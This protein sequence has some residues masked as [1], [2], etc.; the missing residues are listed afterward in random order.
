MRETQAVVSFLRTAIDVNYSIDVS[1]SAT[2][3][4]CTQFKRSTSEFTKGAMSVEHGRTSSDEGTRYV[5]PGV[6]PSGTEPG[7]G[8]AI[9]RGADGVLVE[10]ASVSF[11]SNTKK[12]LAYPSN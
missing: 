2:Q 6:L 9:A 8:I 7:S 11:L 5:A 1:S 12:C 3:L 4:S 10:P